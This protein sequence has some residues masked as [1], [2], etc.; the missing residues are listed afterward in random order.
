MS[1]NKVSIVNVKINEFNQI[2]Y[3]DADDPDENADSDGNVDIDDDNVLVSTGKNGVMTIKTKNHTIIEHMCAKCNKTYKT[4]K[5]KKCFS[6][7]K[8]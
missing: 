7:L 1:N 3:I 4:V 2:E 6:Y 8:K 5:V